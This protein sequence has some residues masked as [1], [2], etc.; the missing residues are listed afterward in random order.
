[1]K[2]DDEEFKKKY[3]GKKVEELVK[4]AKNFN[5]Q[6]IQNGEEL[7]GLLWYL[8]KKKRFREYKGYEKLDFKVF[9]FEIC[10]IPYNR[11]R[12]LVY[13]YNWYPVESREYGP[14]TIQTIREKVGSTKIPK[15]LAEIKKNVSKAKTPDKRR[16]AISDIIKKHTPPKKV[17]P[18]TDTKSY[19]RRKYDELLDK[20]KM[21]E[22]ENNE[23]RAQ[24][25]KQ[26]VP[27]ENLQKV[28]DIVQVAVQ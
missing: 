8:E 11:Y 26:R 25:A 4:L 21:L 2:Y 23:M 3:G 14:Q 10:H 20:Y 15:I 18:A 1:M 9:L 17:V 19:W 28:R 6:M 27:L 13:A 12:Q 16:E 5:D 7:V 24:L 22:K